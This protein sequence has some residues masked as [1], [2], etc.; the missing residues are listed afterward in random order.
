[1][2]LPII[3]VSKQTVSQFSSEFSKPKA[4]RMVAWYRIARPALVLIIW[5][6]AASYIR[7]C[8]VHADESE[9]SLD[10]FMPGIVGM[11][12]IAVAMVAW[13]IARSLVVGHAEHAPSHAD[14]TDGAI[15]PAAA[16]RSPDA[17]R[18]MVAYHDDDGNIS[19]VEALADAA[20]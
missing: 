4:V 15:S 6:L 11:T 9:L 16:S 5:V 8:I 12:A 14:R 18:C 19:R 13:T 2:D 20:R 10:A 7:W 3:D 17:G 1:M